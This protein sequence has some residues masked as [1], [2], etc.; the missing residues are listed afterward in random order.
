MG[1]HRNEDDDCEMFSDAAPNNDYV[2]GG[3]VA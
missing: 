2:D 3:G 1:F